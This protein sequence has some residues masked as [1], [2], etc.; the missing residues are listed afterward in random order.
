MRKFAI[1]I[2]LSVLLLGLTACDSAAYKKAQKLYDAG[3]YLSAQMKFESL[4]DYEDSAEK[5]LLCRY[6]LADEALQ[7]KAYESAVSQFEALGQYEDAEQ[8]CIESRGLYAEQL[9]E[10]GEYQAARDQLQLVPES[11]EQKIQLYRIAWDML[12]EY[13]AAE[14]AVEIK[15]NQYDMAESI[16]VESVCQIS[17]QGKD[18]VATVNSTETQSFGILNV[19]FVTVTDTTVTFGGKQV[20]PELNAK[21]EHTFSGTNGGSTFQNV[22]TAVWDLPSYKADTMITWDEH[23]H[24]TAEGEMDDTRSAPAF[25][26]RVSAHQGLIISCLEK[27]LDD[28][29]LGLTLADLGFVS[30]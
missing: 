4:G 29:E 3:D 2:L 21:A 15:D 12:R 20:L 19:K 7:N 9:R 23:I 5:V 30:Y 11:V 25:D 8:K 1:G 17:K 22:G 18:V 24:I 16:Q 10:Q 6:A 28:S 13:L 14:G 26:E 27:I